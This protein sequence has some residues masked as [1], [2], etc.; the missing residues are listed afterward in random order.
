MSNV[1]LSTLQWTRVVCVLEREVEQAEQG[2]E[3]ATR[4]YPALKGELQSRVDDLRA[5]LA[6]LS[7]ARDAAYGLTPGSP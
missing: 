1:N 4:H 6:T 2:L 7:A 5:A 3:A